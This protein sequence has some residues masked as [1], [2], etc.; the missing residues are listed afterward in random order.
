MPKPSAVSHG[1]LLV[2]VFYQDRAGDPLDVGGV[3]QSW[4]QK[5]TGAHDGAWLGNSV[6]LYRYVDDNEPTEYVFRT[7]PTATMVGVI[8]AFGDSNL[9]NDTGVAITNAP[10]MN[11]ST[12][13][14]TSH[15]TGVGASFS[16]ESLRVVFWMSPTGG[17][18]HS[19]TLPTHYPSGLSVQSSDKQKMLGFAHINWVFNPYLAV[20]TTDWTTNANVTLTRETGAT[21]DGSGTTTYGRMV[22]TTATGDMLAFNTNRAGQSPNTQYVARV[23]VRTSTAMDI[24]LAVDFYN[25]SVVFISS[26]STVKAVPAN[27][28]TPIEFTTTSPAGTASVLFSVGQYAVPVGTV[29]EFTD[30]LLNTKFAAGNTNWN[31][32]SGTTG[33]TGTNTALTHTVNGGVNDPTD[34]V[35]FWDALYANATHNI[36]IQRNVA[37]TGAMWLVSNNFTLPTVTSDESIMLDTMLKAPAGGN[38]WFAILD[39][40]DSGGNFLTNTPLTNLTLTADKWTRVFTIGTKHASAT[41]YRIV[42]GSDAK[43]QNAQLDI[44]F[45][46][47]GEHRGPVTATSSLSS[48]YIAGNFLVGYTAGPQKTESASSEL[49]LNAVDPDGMVEMEAPAAALLYLGTSAVGALERTG[50][51]LNRITLDV[52][53]L[54]YKLSEGADPAVLVLG[55]YSVGDNPNPSTSVVHVVGPP[56]PLPRNKRRFIAQ[57]ALTREITHWDVPIADD[58]VTVTLSGP[59]AITGKIEPDMARELIFPGGQTVLEPYRTILHCEENGA[60]LASCILLPGDMDMNSYAIKAEGFTGYPHGLPYM[61]EYSKTDVDPIDVMRE[62][63]RHLQ[64]FPDSNLRLQINPDI[65]STTRLGNERETPDDPKSPMKPFVLNWWDNK[66]CGSIIDEMAKAAPFEYVEKSWWNADQTD[67][68]LYLDIASPR[69]G[70][71]RDNLRFAQGENIIEAITVAE[72][73]DWYANVIMAVGPGEGRDKLLEVTPGTAG[74]GRL[75]RVYTYVNENITDKAQLKNI[76]A[77][78]LQRRLVTHEIASITIDG[79]HRNAKRGTF[80]VGDDILVQVEIPWIGE[81]VLKHRITEYTHDRNTDLMQLKLK[82]SDA[83]RYGFEA[84]TTGGS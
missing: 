4:T 70:T 73:E 83:F 63:W 31:F 5:P 58:Q 21:I 17:S 2:A 18:T 61:G 15:T 14:S 76:A 40:L 80:G 1:D 78:E 48:G 67:V 30:A 82:R 59:S 29:I 22:K 9:L 24:Q 81:V 55:N 8:G 72:P 74:L 19:Y 64:T 75:R 32:A 34:E 11:S 43:P 42:I 44:G 28:W 36:R 52:T 39:Q 10:G 25:S 6:V 35:A 3:N 84:P 57:N 56:K 16:D 54:G 65:H 79:N 37:G 50:T 77:N 26:A 7:T 45:A 12:T 60:F 47:A 20:N 66:D 27:T 68:Q 13:A 23:W 33:Y 51:G 62:V 49:P 46:R 53:S 71:Y 38:Q 69:A 41:Q